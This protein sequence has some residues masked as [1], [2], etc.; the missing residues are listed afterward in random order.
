MLSQSSPA[1][2]PAVVLDG[3]SSP[4]P[5]C[6][7]AAGPQQLIISTHRALYS[8]DG[9]SCLWQLSTGFGHYYGVVPLARGWL[10][11][12]SQSRLAQRNASLFPVANDAL[13]LIRDDGGSGATAGAWMLPTGYL[14]DAVTADDGLL[15]AV[16]TATGRVCEFAIEVAAT[17]IASGALRAATGWLSLA[18]RPSAA[19]VSQHRTIGTVQWPLSAVAHTAHANNVLVTKDLLWVMHNHVLYTPS[20]NILDRHTGAHRRSITLAAD[21]CHNPLFYEGD[22]LYLLSSIGGIGRLAPNGSSVTIWAAGDAWFTKGLAVID[23]V[24]H[25]GISRQQARAVDR[26]DAIAELIALDLGTGKVRLRTAMPGKGLINA[27]SAPRLRHS[28]SWRACE[29]SGA[30]EFF[31][32]RAGHVSSRHDPNTRAWL[33]GATPSA[34][35]GAAA[36]ATLH[37][38]DEPVAAPALHSSVG[39][40]AVEATA[41]ALAA[42]ATA[43]AT[44]EAPPLA[45]CEAER[46]PRTLPNV[47]NAAHRRHLTR[48]FFEHVHTQ[49]ARGRRTYYHLLRALLDG[50]E[51]EAIATRAALEAVRAA[52]AGAFGDGFAV[53]NDFFSYRSAAS[54]D[55]FPEWHQDYEFWLTPRCAN[56]NLWVLLDHEQMNHSFEL[57]ERDAHNGWVYERLYA[58]AARSPKAATRAAAASSAARRRSVGRANSSRAAAAPMHVPMIPQAYFRANG[59]QERLPVGAPPAGAAEPRVSR[60]PLGRGDALILKQT[61]VHRTDRIPLQ[62]GQWRLAIGF[63]VLERA[64]LQR[65]PL[66]NSPFAGD[67]ATMG[68][69]WPGLLPP[70]AVHRPFPDVYDAKRLSTLRDRPRPQQH[71]EALS[72][73]VEENPLALISVVLPLMALGLTALAVAQRTGV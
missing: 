33:R 54:V 46:Y 25:F 70:L 49:P 8:F 37:R 29:T 26:N 67:F 6:A 55:L 36:S 44:A 35:A 53:V 11:V 45:T 52:I 27:V 66:Y 12:G 22:V 61:E 1:L 72:R 38:V 59:R 9:G 13:L 73:S 5:S 50:D 48:L 7:T 41:K 14:H 62:P 21:N 19:R 63:K 18:P 31:R 65:L 60:V 30:A 71:A 2:L 10:L 57:Y 47:L 64:P 3:H 51:A 28:C 43:E 69:L 32:G 16:D 23:G 34:S 17:A 56:F 4:G 15:Y 20:L 58:H 40:P 68:V 24:A 39:E 42:E